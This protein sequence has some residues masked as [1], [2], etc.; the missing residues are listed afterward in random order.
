MKLLTLMQAAEFLNSWFHE[1]QIPGLLGVTIS[2]ASMGHMRTSVIYSEEKLRPSEV[3]MLQ[4]NMESL[5]PGSVI[6]RARGS[7]STLVHISAPYG[8]RR[9]SILHIPQS[10]IIRHS[11]KVNYVVLVHYVERYKSYYGFRYVR[12]FEEAIWKCRP[13]SISKVGLK[14]L[15]YSPRAKF[16]SEEGGKVILSWNP[17]LQGPV[18]LDLT[19]EQSKIFLNY[20]IEKNPKF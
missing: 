6:E 2:P 10:N 3:S 15:S 20:N 4:F 7:M 9:F 14:P 13:E 12:N 11:R 1:F 5:F 18:F 16:I 17:A 8:E 19:P